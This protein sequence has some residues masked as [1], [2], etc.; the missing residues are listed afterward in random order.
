MAIELYTDGAAT[1]RKVNGEYIREAGGWAWAEIKNGKVV[2]FANG[3]LKQTTNNEQE[4]MAILYALQHVKKNISIGAEVKI[5]S[6]SAYCINIFTQWAKSWEKNGW[7]RGKKREPIENLNLIK[8]IYYLIQDLQEKFF[9]VTFI[10]VK[11]H[12]TDKFNQFVDKMAVEAKISQ[13]NA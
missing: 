8:E 12:S 3:G 4:L 2:E 13:A 5:Y 9:T 7:V 10:K 11:G 6:D 1:M